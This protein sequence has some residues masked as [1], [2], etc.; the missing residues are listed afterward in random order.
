MI[1]AIK[2]ALLNV[3]LNSTVQEVELTHA[4]YYLVYKINFV[5]EDMKKYQV[6]LDPGNGEVLLKKEITWYDNHEKMNSY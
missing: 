5:D 4:Q 1:Y 2:A 6:I 3:G